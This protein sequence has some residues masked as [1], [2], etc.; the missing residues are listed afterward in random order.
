MKRF[1]FGILF[2]SL[3]A[4]LGSYKAN[5]EPT[6]ADW[7][8]FG[9]FRDPALDQL[10][11]MKDARTLVAYRS[12]HD[13]LYGVEERYFSIRFDHGGAFDPNK[14]AATVV[15]PTGSS[16]QKQLLALHMA[17][18]SASF[19]AVLPKITVRRVTV[20]TSTCGAL[21]TRMDSLANVRIGLQRRDRIYLPMHRV[22]HHVVVDF[23]D[24]I[25]V[26]LGDPES[27]LARW[28]TSTMDM[29]FKCAG[30]RE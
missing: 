19:E 6:D 20:Q 29:L 16:I 7:D 15:V 8:W 4:P 18:R 1:L 10:M 24:R 11:P 26:M 13:L 3:A 25:D 28:A 22:W 2:V 12:H 9:R 17:D 14:L 30:Q 5:Q 21:P 23:S 27:A